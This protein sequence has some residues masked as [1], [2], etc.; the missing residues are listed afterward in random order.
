MRHPGRRTP[1]YVVVGRHRGSADG[2]QSNRK[3]T[4]TGLSWLTPLLEAALAFHHAVRGAEDDL[5]AVI[6][7]LREATVNGD[8]AY[9]VPIAAAMGD[10]PR[11]DGP[12]I[13]W[14][15]DECTVRTP[16]RALVTARQDRLHGRE[17]ASGPSPA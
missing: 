4:V 1:L 6:D 12:T 10:Q 13:R 3:V 14:L 16:W 8:F 15:D 11:P 2:A 5:D 17:L 9:Y 7:R